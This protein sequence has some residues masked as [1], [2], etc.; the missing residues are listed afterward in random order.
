MVNLRRSVKVTG[1]TF[2]T[3]AT[4]LSS[5]AE[6]VA[7]KRLQ[8]VKDALTGVT[9]VVML[10]N[11]ENPGHLQVTRETVQ[12]STQLGIQLETHGVRGASDLPEVFQAAAR[13]RAQVLF[14]QDDVP[15]TLLKRPI[16]DQAA[17]QSLPVFAQYRE[18]AE[19]GALVTFAHVLA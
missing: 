12:A 1:V 17:R 9:R 2:R 16:L 7:T 14:V 6:E 13:G 8:L 19:A 11:A 3:V 4:G 5:I 10:F 15:I 18:F